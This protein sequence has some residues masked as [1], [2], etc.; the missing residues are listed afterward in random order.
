MFLLPICSQVTSENI[1][2]LSALYKLL[3][4]VGMDYLTTES[5]SNENSALTEIKPF[6]DKGEIIHHKILKAVFHF[7]Q[8]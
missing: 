5:I 7:L 3:S 4:N 6:D 8:G 2:L 1:I